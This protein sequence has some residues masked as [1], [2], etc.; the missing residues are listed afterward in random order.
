MTRPRWRDSRRQQVTDRE[1]PGVG[2][3]REEAV[4][5]V[6]MVGWPQE[7]QGGQGCTWK[8]KAGNM[9]GQGGPSRQA[10]E[11]AEPDNS[12]HPETLQCLNGTPGVRGAVGHAHLGSQPDQAWAL[13]FQRV[14]QLLGVSCP[15]TLRPLLSGLCSPLPPHPPA[16]LLPISWGPRPPRP[17]HSR[18]GDGA[19]AL[20]AGGVPDLRL[21]GLAV[22]LDAAGGELHAD[23]ALALQVEL[24]AGEARQQ[25]ALPHAR[26]PDEHHFGR[27]ERYE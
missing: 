1:W 6:L 26:V 4:E 7:G 8:R 16:Q 5:G 2:R 15:S 25:V 12:P 17:R 22:H 18:R 20:L 21:D 24:V 19:V 23:G 14:P 11:W 27:G 3:V 10:G 9:A 13:A